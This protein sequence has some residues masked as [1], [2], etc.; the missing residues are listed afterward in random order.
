MLSHPLDNDLLQFLFMLAEK[1]IRAFHLSHGHVTSG[2]SVVPELICH[3]GIRQVISQTVD[4]KNRFKKTANVH[5]WVG[6][7]L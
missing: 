2:S 3:L 6:K 1:V 5:E 4:Y 7:G